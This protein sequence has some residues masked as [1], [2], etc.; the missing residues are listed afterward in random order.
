MWLPD[1]RLEQPEMMEIQTKPHGSVM[2]NPAFRYK[3][4]FYLFR[5]NV[6]EVEVSGIDAFPVTNW[7]GTHSGEDGGIVSLTGTQY[8]RYLAAPIN[9]AG[10]SRCSLFFR[11]KT[12]AAPTGNDLIFS[13]VPND[14]ANPTNPSISLW[15]DSFGYT[16]SSPYCCSVI[17]GTKSS[18]RIETDPNS[19]IPNKYHNIMIVLDGPNLDGFCVFDGKPYEIVSGSAPSSIYASYDDWFFGYNTALDQFTGSV[20]AFYVFPDQVISRSESAIITRNPFGMFI[21]T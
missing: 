9:I 10:N 18:G 19:I 11:F 3:G 21:P 6:N 16:T 20:S 7:T 2:V 14:Y 5:R 15:A 1:S 13:M 12:T 8:L 17:I 4:A